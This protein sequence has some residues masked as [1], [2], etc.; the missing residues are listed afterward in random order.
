MVFREEPIVGNSVISTS[1]NSKI[2]MHFLKYI[3]CNVLS[4]FLVMLS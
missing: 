2:M 3:I 4:S 1:R